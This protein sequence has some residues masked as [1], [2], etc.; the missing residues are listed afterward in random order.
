MQALEN[1]RV[2]VVTGAGRGLGRALADR[3]LLHGYRVLVTDIAAALAAATA[4]ELGEE[5]WAMTQ[6]VR[7]PRSHQQIADAAQER[8]LLQLWINNAGVL[9][10]GTA[11]E[12]PD[13]EIAHQVDVNMLGVMY[14]TN[15]AIN[16]MG[17]RGGHIV[18]IASMAAL[19]PVPGMAVY[20]ASKHAVLAYSTSIQG[21]LDDAG[22][23]IRV[24]TFCHDAVDARPTR[25]IQR[26]ENAALMFSGRRLLHVEDVADRVIAALD[27]EQLAV[28]YPRRRGALCRALAPFPRVGLR[29]I[30]QARRLGER[31]RRRLQNY[32]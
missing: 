6:D 28:S 8:G 14:G 17:E 22:L 25:D 21:E 7:D 12:Q 13:S 9:H 31:H 32:D 30:R 19:C 2:A 20:A 11:W 26:D 15:A 4:E 18:N 27:G 23:P 1:V 5:C 29:V 16:T 24:L 10:S 3:L